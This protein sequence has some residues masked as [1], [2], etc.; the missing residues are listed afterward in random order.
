M[1]AGLNEVIH[2]GIDGRGAAGIVPRAPDGSRSSMSAMLGAEFDRQAVPV[3]DIRG[4]RAVRRERE[5]AWHSVFDEVRPCEHRLRGTG[6]IDPPFRDSQSWLPGVES[7]AARTAGPDAS[8]LARV[9]SPRRV[10]FDRRSSLHCSW[11]PNGIDDKKRTARRRSK[12]RAEGDGPG[13]T[14]GCSSRVHRRTH[15]REAAPVN[16]RTNFMD[17]ETGQQ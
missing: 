4:R 5:N 7:V 2:C 10:C 15:V 13:Q 17:H 11:T 14:L 8:K 16:G 1:R 12:P 9:S 3:R 6:D